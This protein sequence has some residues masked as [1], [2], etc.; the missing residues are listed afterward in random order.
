MFGAM[1]LALGGLTYRGGSS[2]VG[3]GTI[4][5]IAADYTGVA[6]YAM[7]ITGLELLDFEIVETANEVPKQLVVKIVPGNI[8]YSGARKLN[9]KAVDDFTDFDIRIVVSNRNGDPVPDYFGVLH[10]D[11][12]EAVNL[13]TDRKV[14]TFHG[15]IPVSGDYDVT[16][17]VRAPSGTDGFVR[18]ASLKTEL[19]TI[20]EC[21]LPTFFYDSDDGDSANDGKDQWGVSLA[22]AT[23]TDSTQ[24]IEQTGAFTLVDT[25]AATADVCP[26][27]HYNYIYLNGATEGG[28]PVGL[29]KFTKL[30]DNQI[31]LEESLGANYTNVTS[32]NGPKDTIP[33]TSLGGSRHFYSGPYA[34]TANLGLSST[35]Y[36]LIGY[37][38][39]PVITRP[40]TDEHVMSYGFGGGGSIPGIG[41][42]FI[43]NVIVDGEYTHNCIGVAMSASGGGTVRRCFHRV[44][45]QHPRSQSV[46]MSQA[47]SGVWVNTISFIQCELEQL[48]S[49]RQ[50]HTSAGNLTGTTDFIVKEPIAPGTSQTGYLWY[51]D[52]NGRIRPVNG[53]PAFRIPYTSHDGNFRYTLES[54]TVRDSP[55]GVYVVTGGPEFYSYNTVIDVK[56]R[57]SDT[58]M[59]AC[60]FRSDCGDDTK[61]HDFYLSGYLDNALVEL[62]DF[63]K[64]MGASYAVNGNLK[65][66][67]LDHIHYNIAFVDNKLSEYRLFGFDCSITND[68]GAWPA[69]TAR[70]LLVARNYSNVRYRLYFGTGALT[71]RFTRNTDIDTAGLYNEYTLNSTISMGG[72]SLVNPADVHVTADNNITRDRQFL[73]ADNGQTQFEILDNDVQIDFD[74]VTMRIPS[75]AYADGVITNNNLYN[76]D[77]T[78]GDV[79][80]I[81]NVGYTIEEFNTEVDGAN[82]RVA[83]GPT[84]TEVFADDFNRAN[85]RLESSTD[86]EVLEDISTYSLEINSNQVYNRGAFATRANYTNAVIADDQYAKVT[87]ITSGPSVSAYICGRIDSTTANTDAERYYVARLLINTDTG[88][89]DV[90]VGKEKDGVYTTIGTPASVTGIT[91]TNDLELRCVGSEIS[92]YLND[93]LVTTETDVDAGFV[94]GFA[95]IRIVYDNDGVS[96]CRLDNFSCGNIT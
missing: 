92:V 73:R 41:N 45:F 57:D 5:P 68:L 11:T 31:Q 44:K 66:L 78:S 33:T 51:L 69:E 46:A 26:I 64:G 79:A 25:D 32:S 2:V 88:E 80:L 63:G 13:L 15:I 16:V 34:R 86:W 76:P 83:G 19:P 85:G 61:D 77:S 35:G 20:T 29:Y 94:S 6:N 87:C 71:S 74:G 37:K 22:T 42:V 70:G 72:S 47:G 52:Q 89:A 28:F 14:G 82:T 48:I 3:K 10:P 4:E 81:D 59:V 95:G 36:Q 75:T 84:L 27:Y 55:D 54:G 18:L 91:N 9:S 50:E 40:G 93:V 56:G 21:T 38:N 60:K 39:R 62:C 53:G 17:Y 65:S 1:R 67:T 30:N 23:Y 7:G 49:N 96:D 24:I 12:G 43:G 8:S 90:S 58:A